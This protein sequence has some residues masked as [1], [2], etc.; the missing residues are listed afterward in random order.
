MCYYL[1]QESQIKINS[2]IHRFQYLS[3]NITTLSN[4]LKDSRHTIGN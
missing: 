2:T 4:Q 1:E 3:R